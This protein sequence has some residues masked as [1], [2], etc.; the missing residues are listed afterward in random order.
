MS[1]KLCVGEIFDSNQS[2][3]FNWQVYFK[4][5]THI[6]NKVHALQEL[7]FFFNLVNILQLWNLCFV[8]I[9]II[10][11]LILLIIGMLHDI[12]KKFPSD[13]GGC[14]QGKLHQFDL[15]SNFLLSFQIIES[16]AM[17]ARMVYFVR[18]ELRL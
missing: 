3:S 14:L 11:W 10:C 15:Y 12:S 6:E 17:V 9:H 8:K 2:Y 4:H 1:F 13:G 5:K 16:D 18:H 7:Y